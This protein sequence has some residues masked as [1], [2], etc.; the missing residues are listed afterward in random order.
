MVFAARDEAETVTEFSEDLGQ[1]LALVTFVLFG[2]VLVG[3]A[4]DEVTFAILACAVGTL[5]ISRMLPVAVALIGSGPKAPTVAF[6]GWFGPRG[7]ASIVLGLV[8]LEEAG[9]A[10]G[11]EVFV[12]ATWTV[13][14]SIVAHGA[15]ATWAAR[16]CG[17]WYM[18]TP[19]DMRDVM[20][21]SEETTVARARF[22]PRPDRGL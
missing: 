10:A 11:D 4:L 13:L 6:I 12:I 19:D 14:L 7:L 18:A 9:F 21:K 22:A 15:S 17:E 2:N 8:V 20:M 1:P 16:R 5:T 3:P